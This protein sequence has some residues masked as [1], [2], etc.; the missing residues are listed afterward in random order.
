VR[1]ESFYEQLRVARNGFW[2]LEYVLTS[3]IRNRMRSYADGVRPITSLTTRVLPAASTPQYAIVLPDRSSLADYSHVDIGSA[4]YSR[5]IRELHMT[6]QF[7]P[8]TPYDE[9]ERQL[10]ARIDTLEPPPAD[11]YLRQAAAVVADAAAIEARGGRVMF[12][13]L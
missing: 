5:V 8:G 9:I 4:Y 6:I 11:V 2:T 10:Q 1:Y 7:A 3:A 13:V 12:V